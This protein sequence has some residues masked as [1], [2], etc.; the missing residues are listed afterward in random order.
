MS[1]DPAISVPGILL[2]GGVLDRIVDAKARRLERAKTMKPL[3]VLQKSL[4]EPLERNR[5][6][7]A[8]S[9]SSGIGVIA[10]LKHRSPSKGVLR[11]V[12][13]PVAIA[14]SYE[15]AGATA[16][17]VLTEEDFFDGSL[18]H[19]RAVGSAVPL[20]PILRKDFVFDEYQV[21]ESAE[22][23][24]SAV[25]LIVAILSDAL[26][27]QLIELASRVGL[28]ALVEVHNEE[29]IARALRA[30][31]KVIG[32]NNRDL[33]DFS[34]KLETSPRLAALAPPDVL[35]VSE[36]GISSRDDIER[37]RQAGFNAVLVGEHFMRAQDP[38][39]ALRRLMS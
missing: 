26:L 30:D 12:Y 33:T 6:S 27:S 19:L 13:D 1:S 4:A 5:L 32:V 29:E 39:E 3:S 36:S 31:A 11:D 21:F 9:S 17:S 24:A 22:A 15:A 18:D 37:L 7:R 20:I 2:A 38:G 16:L 8:L 10:E 34:V 25:L 14:R 35:L 23:G 28:D